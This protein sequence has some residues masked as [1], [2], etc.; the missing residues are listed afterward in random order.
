LHWVRGLVLAIAFALTPL[1]AG[2]VMPKWLQDFQQQQKK[3]E[4]SRWTL[5]DWLAQ[6][7]K[8]RLMD[9]WLALNTSPVNFEG[10][11][12]GLSFSYEGESDLAP[13]VTNEDD[14]SRGWLSLYYRIFG[15]TGEFE[16]WPGEITA[17][18]YLF[19]LRL[20]GTSLQS[21]QLTLH[22][23]V[24][25]VEDANGNVGRKNNFGAATLTIYIFQFFGLDSHYRQYLAA[26]DSSDTESD[27]NS[28]SY[29][30]FLE[31]GLLR[32]FGRVATEEWNYQPLST[33]AY[34]TTSKGYEVGA[35]LFF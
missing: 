29:G 2:A 32:V 24:N 12:G 27:G 4:S 14:L 28:L 8:V 17:S 15:I 23:G 5:E 26:K 9:Y 34:T 22:Y 16:N 33:S 11:L 19:N 3:K 13:G 6:K 20:L 7:Q 31:L 25:Q 18:S 10:T 21:T 1:T 30:V 35:Q